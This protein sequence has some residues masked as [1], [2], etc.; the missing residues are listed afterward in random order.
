[1]HTIDGAG[2]RPATEIEVTPEMIEAA[3]EAFAE[4]YC[5]EVPSSFAKFVAIA[6][7]SMRTIERGRLP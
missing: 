5:E 7:R 6:Y 1:M 3:W 4:N 2:D